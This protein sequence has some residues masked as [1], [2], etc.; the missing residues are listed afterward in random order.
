MTTRGSVESRETSDVADADPARAHAVSLAGT[1]FVPSGF[2]TTTRVDFVVR[3]RVWS[4]S[5]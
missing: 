5:R 4:G 2:R 1:R 3:V